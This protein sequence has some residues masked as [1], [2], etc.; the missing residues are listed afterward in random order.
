MTLSGAFRQPLTFFELP[1]KSTRA[2]DPLTVTFVFTRMSSVPAP[3]SSRE[4]ANEYSP[5]GIPSTAF[6]M[7]VSP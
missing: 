4:S 5:S 3:S 1:R 7:S 2:E 6:F